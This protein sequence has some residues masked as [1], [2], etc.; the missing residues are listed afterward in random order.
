MK[1]YE[2]IFN[3]PKH[4]PFPVEYV[5]DGEM[6]KTY[7]FPI[8]TREEAKIHAMNAIDYYR[9]TMFHEYS[10]VDNDYSLSIQETEWNRENNTP[11]LVDK[12]SFNLLTSVNAKD[13]DEIKTKL[14]KKVQYWV[15]LIENNIKDQNGEL[16]DK[17]RVAGINK[18]KSTNE[19]ILNNKKIF[20][21]PNT[22][23]GHYLGCDITVYETPDEEVEICIDTGTQKVKAYSKDINNN[24]KT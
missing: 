7:K 17:Y 22:D 5:V 20:L 10:D 1:C 3:D 19:Y 8:Q 23:D 15:D 24:N 4:G 11:V 16:L 2:L 21:Y 6:V 9:D 14:Q 18:Y 12:F 13:Y